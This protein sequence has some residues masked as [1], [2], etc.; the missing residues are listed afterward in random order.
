MEEDKRRKLSISPQ[1]TLEI[2]MGKKNSDDELSTEKFQETFDL[3]STDLMEVEEDKI[4]KSEFTTME[5]SRKNTNFDIDPNDDGIEQLFKAYRSEDEEDNDSKEDDEVASKGICY[6]IAA[7][8]DLVCRKGVCRPSPRVKEEVS[9]IGID[10]TVRK[11]IC[12]R[13]ENY[14]LLTCINRPPDKKRKFGTEG[15]DSSK[16]QTII[17]T[18]IFK[19]TDGDIDGTGGRSGVGAGSG[20]DGEGLDDGSIPVA[21]V[22]ECCHCAICRCKPK[23]VKRWLT[24]SGMDVKK[25]GLLGQGKDR[26][27]M[28]YSW[29]TVHVPDDWDF[30]RDQ[31]NV[32]KSEMEELIAQAEKFDRERK[33]ILAAI[34]SEGGEEEEEE[35][36]EYDIGESSEERRQR[37]TEDDWA[38]YKAME[39][40]GLR[41]QY[42]KGVAPVDE[43][44]LDTYSHVS[45]TSQPPPQLLLGT[46][47][48]KF[49]KTTSTATDAY[50]A[51]SD[52]SSRTESIEIEQRPSIYES[53]LPPLPKGKSKSKLHK[54]MSRTGVIDENLLP[55][56]LKREAHKFKRTQQSQTKAVKD[57]AKKSIP[58]K[59]LTVHDAARLANLQSLDVGLLNTHSCPCLPGFCT[60]EGQG[61]WTIRQSEIEM[62]RTGK[63]K[64]LEPTE[65]E[66]REAGIYVWKGYEC[67]CIHSYEDLQ[68]SPESSVEFM[69]AR[70]PA[71]KKVEEDF[72]C[73]CT[74]RYEQTVLIVKP[75]AMIFE[76]VIRR[77][78]LYVGGLQIVNERKIRLSPEQVSEIYEDRYYGSQSYPLFVLKMSRHPILV[79]CIA[80]LK[81]IDVVKSMIGED[82]LIPDSWF[83]PESIKRRI[84][85]TDDL[86]DTIQVSE[87][88]EQ[89][90]MECK[91]FFPQTMIEPIPTIQSRVNDFCKTYLDPTLSKGLASV[92][93]TK[94]IDPIIFLAEWLLTHNPYQ[95]W[96]KPKQINMVPI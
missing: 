35:Y 94:P 50:S 51:K 31:E 3:E 43:K 61:H 78:I 1:G 72:V 93:R 62:K 96:Y 65:S 6:E 4:F 81:C 63:Q 11:K 42:I 17:E 13:P 86:I 28:V 89:F 33:E 58:H 2:S 60:C 66:L 25:F 56:G 19:S 22:C 92:A 30:A 53:H 84:V 20:A 47:T 14:G 87:D 27:R 21:E 34:A 71:R 40:A 41:H 49:Q 9:E 16:C 69:V 18:T 82:K 36:E 74:K 8:P 57:K 45:W 24:E 32:R 80:G 55:L 5:S 23:F 44:V 7:N 70:S 48:K 54:L 67:P 88:A 52:S 46:T 73:T 90:A 37:M 77:A 59:A 79:L 38:R 95:P 76:D 39:W 12:H 85:A 26:I 83:L 75:D 91:Y 15:M 10:Y 68:V 64:K 29:D